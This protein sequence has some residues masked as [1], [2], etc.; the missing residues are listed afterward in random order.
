M[1]LG[2]SVVR[3]IV[4]DRE[5][6]A[7]RGA[8]IDASPPHGD[9]SFAQD[10]AHKEVRMTSMTARINPRDIVHGLLTAAASEAPG[11]IGGVLKLIID[12][13]I[14]PKFLDGWLFPKP[15]T[16]LFNQFKDRIQKMI[17]KEIEVAVGQATFDRVKARITGLADAFRGFGNV[18]DFDERRVRL[19]YLLTLADATVA[20]VE[21]VPD[22]YLYLLTEQLQIVAI[23]NIAVLI[24]QVKMH[25]DR[26]E[27]QL[28]LNQAAIRYSDLSGRIRDRFL[29]YRM[30]QIAEGRGA[31]EQRDVDTRQVFSQPKQKKVRFIAYDDFRYWYNNPYGY[32]SDFLNFLT[33][34]WVLAD[35]VDPAY[36]AM[37]QKA[38][39]MVAAYGE[40]CQQEVYT[41]WDEHLTKTTADFMQ[42]VDWPG[43]KG[44]RKPRD[45]MAVQAYP[46]Q[47][48]A[49]AT[50]ATPQLERIDLYLGQQMDQFS[51]SGPRYTQTYRLPG[52]VK[53]GDQGNMFYRADTYD[54]SVAAIY[55]TLRNQLQRATDLADALCTAMEHD[56]LGGGRIVAA[57][58]AT[59]VVDSDDNYATSVFFPDGGTRDIGNM[60]WAGLALTRLYAK[61]RH[62]RYLYCAQVIGNWIR[63][64]CTVNDA[65]QGFSG[66]ED[67]WNAKRLWRS[68]EH[69]VDAY[70]FFRNLHA[71]T[72]DASWQEA[73]NKR[74]DGGPGL[75]QAGRFLCH[76]H[77]QRSDA[78]RWCGAH[79]HAILDGAGQ[80]ESR[81][82]RR[83]SAVHAGQLQHHEWWF[84]WLQVRGQ[85]NWR[86]ERGDRRRGHGAVPPGRH[87][88]RS[89][90]R[91][92]RQS[93]EPAKERS[94]CRW[95][96]AGPRR[97]F[98]R[99]TPVQ[100]LGWKYFNW[101][102][103]ASTAW[104]GLALLAR[105]NAYANPYALVQLST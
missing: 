27:H 40:K 18:V 61:T 79:R 17:E 83:E 46:V 87:I 21:A 98:R 55:F 14:F 32:R 9:A 7:G 74:K 43:E 36:Y 1:A 11:P 44:E 54:T 80:P 25:P 24:D 81:E 29:W 59:A 64:N 86:A 22:R 6:R 102:H 57:T 89:R 69:N 30:G 45:R 31:I 10:P 42:F 5:R 60:C 37:T 77:R 62:F 101:L 12:E 84:R 97:R 56:P 4:P 38:Q 90:G 75:P 48:V 53:F 78:Q 51:I 35:S 73:A 33:T 41:W 67:A 68:V 105:E 20:E 26:Y 19:A 50:D 100:G 76:R 88:P 71:L 104:T 91:V 58:K 28:A 82:Q 66:G 85:R 13:L 70:A 94:Q 2:P 8:I 3:L 49:T 103:V 99:Q 63:A 65:W 95:P 72:Q 92:L 96:G 39:G 34:D 16:D 47:R 23:M 93:G 52:V 15:D